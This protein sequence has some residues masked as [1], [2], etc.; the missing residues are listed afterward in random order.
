LDQYSVDGTTVVYRGVVAEY[1]CTGF[2]WFG[3][4]APTGRTTTVR[5]VVNF[6]STGGRTFGLVTMYCEGRTVCPSWINNPN[7]R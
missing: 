4:C 7:R 5:M 3:G 6:R 2:L 1:R